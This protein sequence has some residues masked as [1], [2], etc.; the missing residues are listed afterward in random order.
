MRRA[1]SWTC[2]DRRLPLVPGPAD[3]DVRRGGLHRATL[4]G[5]QQAADDELSAV[6]LLP[7]HEH[8]GQ[9]DRVDVLGHAETGH[10]GGWRLQV[11]RRAVGAH[12]QVASHQRGRAV[13][14]LPVL[15]VD[16][17][18]HRGSLDVDRRDPRVEPG[19]QPPGATPQQHQHRRHQR[20]PH[21]EGV[22]EDAD[23]QAEG[24]RLDGVG[25][26]GDERGEDRRHDQRGRGDHRRRGAEPAVDPRPAG[27]RTGRTPPASRR[28]GTSRSP[29]PGRRAH[30]SR[31]SAGS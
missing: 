31:R 6:R 26:V 27:R 22:D 28:R 24:D 12:H 17:A 1:R 16:L 5:E 11:D 3:L 30:P 20:H 29:W 19:G 2:S 13:G 7:P 23:G 25:A 8:H 18:V 4:L 10:Q 14:L 9:L 21:Q 15:V